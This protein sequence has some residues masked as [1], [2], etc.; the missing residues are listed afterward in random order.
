ML[1]YLALLLAAVLLV[2][3]RAKWGNA[4]ARG[5]FFVIALPAAIAFWIW[6]FRTVFGG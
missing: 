1:I 3:A 6:L 4:V 5:A 2:A